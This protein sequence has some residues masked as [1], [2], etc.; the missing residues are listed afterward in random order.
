MKFLVLYKTPT[1]VLDTWMETP[2]E[3]RKE[4]ESR[5]SAEW[6]A[7]LKE[8]AD[9]VKETAGAGKTKLITKDGIS[10][11]RNDVMMYSIVEAD[12]QEAAAK[13]FEN[14]S[15]LQIPEATIEVMASN[16]LPGMQ[17]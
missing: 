6:N 12:S 3:E 10:D 16:S 13:I 9:K 2:A 5:M 1:H 14:H 17:Q 7:W 15:H 4:M 8:H 11:A